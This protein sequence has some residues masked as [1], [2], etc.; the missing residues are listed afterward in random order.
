MFVRN[1]SMAVAVCVGLALFNHCGNLIAQSSEPACAADIDF[2]KQIVPLLKARCGSCHARSSKKGGFSI[3]SPESLRAGGDSGPAVVSGNS[4]KSLLIELVSGKDPDRIMP[5]KGKL[6]TAEEVELLGAWIDGGLKWADGF[7]FDRVKAIRIELKQPK[8]PPGAIDAN[9]IDRLLQPYF[10]QRGGTAE[11][12][13]SD[14]VFARRVS[15]DIVG[16]LPSPSRVAEFEADD[17]TDKRERLVDELL[18]NRRAYADHW[19]TFW[20]DVLRNAYRGTGFIDSGRT[21]ITGWLYKSLFDNKPYNQFVRE[22]IDPVPG[23]EGFLKGIKW[24]GVVN[25]SQRR[26]MQA[27]QNVTQIFMAA[28]LKCASCHDSFVNDW[29]LTDAYGLASVFADS[30]LEMHRCN[31]PVGDI[32]APRFIYPQLGQIDAKA[33]LPQRL[34]QLAG[35]LTSPRNGRLSRTIV[36][37]I[38]A[39][40]FGRGLVEPVDDLDQACWNDELLDWLAADLQE[41]GYDLKHT[42]RRICTS[43]AYQMPSVGLRKSD[44]ETFVFR[45]PLVRRMSAEQFVDALSLVTGQWQKVTPGMKAADG[46]S[47][48]GQLLEILTASQPVETPLKSKS[49]WIWS[50]QDAANSDPDGTIYLRKSFTL[51]KKPTNAVVIVACDNEFELIVNGQT[52]KRQKVVGKNHTQPVIRNVMSQLRSGSNVLAVAATNWPDPKNG[53]G[54]EVKGLNPGGF[55]FYMSVVADDQFLTEIVSDSSWRWS[56][57]RVDGWNQLKFNAAAQWKPAIELGGANTAPWR[58][59]RKLSALLAVHSADDAGAL[60]NLRSVL[61]DNDPLLRGLGRPNR[62]QVVTRRDSQ[63][64]LLQALELTNGETLNQILQE[65]AK[66]WLKRSRD[67]DGELVEQ[68]YL[69]AFGRKP[70]TNETAAAAELLESGV[71]QDA[72]A[73]L[74]WILVML[75]E[76]QLIY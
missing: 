61:A 20:N 70:T 63:A 2:E 29:S 51:D 37:R 49:K 50:H 23:S 73:D 45:G 14:R 34:K 76:F 68:L 12:V 22:L 74:L 15:L 75:P 55:Y 8:L 19:M 4:G 26:E 56:D 44:A 65:G 9:P 25:A 69:T 6:L 52:G 16:L 39:I 41:H 32:V 60:P 46:R 17:R 38:W 43:H 7:R 13:V 57:E 64:T 18:E 31:K 40:Y 28:N 5:A 36:N 35:I 30:A 53:K 71:T 3:N 48:G 24:R 54:V 47:Q 27:A 58:M 59:G 33:A 72:V 10:L 62:E 66:S 67:S 11:T 1:F 42:I 21:Q